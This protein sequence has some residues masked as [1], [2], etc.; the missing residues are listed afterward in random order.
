MKTEKSQEV[1]IKEIQNNP[2]YVILSNSLSN[3]KFIKSIG[4]AT[5]S[6][7]LSDLY[8]PKIFVQIISK[9]TPQHLENKIGNYVKIDFHLNEFLN[10][11]GI[12]D[13]R[14]YHSHILESIK[15]MQSISVQYEDKDTIFGFSLIPAYEFG[16]NK[17]H[18][19][20]DIHENIVREILQVNQNSNFS[21][22]KQYL[23]R[24]SNSQAVKLF[25]FF[26]SWKN[27]GFVELTLDNF[28]KKFGY[29][30]EGYSRFANLKLKVLDPAI[31]DINDKTTLD[32]RYEILSQNLKSKKPRVDGL[33]FIIKEKDKK[34]LEGKTVLEKEAILVEDQKNEAD[35][36]DMLF[37]K[38]SNTVIDAFGVNPT[39]FF[40]IIENYSDVDI[41]RAVE[42]TEKSH[43]KK[44]IDNIAGFFVEALK[45][46]YTDMDEI[47]RMQDNIKTI[48]AK[49][50]KD[51][52][53]ITQKTKDEEKRLKS[54]Q[55][56]EQVLDLI[57]KDIKFADAVFQKFKESFVGRNFLD[58]ALE[59]VLNSN[60][61]KGAFLSEA[62]KMIEK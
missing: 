47:K 24:L 5:L 4:K 13:K 54:I 34:Q 23:F 33:R 45:N 35:E 21:Y 19:I 14:G 52:T 59:D 27:K 32:V 38:Y 16:K 26:V 37:K 48:K 56:D 18:L 11:V 17:G 9:L 6:Q 42:L 30:T 3:P 39:A 60:L 20:L 50:E 46:K 43:A 7:P 44:K 61:T 31:N 28:K 58:Y 12:V 41:K 29:D 40:K 49:K 57:A 51:K 10:D 25:Q 53:D 1:V 55:E 22:L 2:D 15:T 8:I 62:K 36:K